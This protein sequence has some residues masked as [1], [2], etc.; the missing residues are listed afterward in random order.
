MNILINVI[1][2][3]LYHQQECSSTPLRT[4]FHI[5]LVERISPDQPK[6]NITLL[7]QTQIKTNVF[8]P[9]KQN[10]ISLILIRHFKNEIC[11]HNIIQ[12]NKIFTEI[13]FGTKK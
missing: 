6:N 10:S 7:K 9:Q 2:N 12:T 5:T 13:A 4:N 8:H 3:Y 11:S 1:V